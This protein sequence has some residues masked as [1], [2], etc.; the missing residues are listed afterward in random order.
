MVRALTSRMSISALLGIV[1]AAAFNRVLNFFLLSMVLATIFGAVIFI[2]SSRRLVNGVQD[3]KVRNSLYMSS[4]AAVLSTQ[5]FFL[6]FIPLTVDRSFSVWLLARIGGAEL[7]TETVETLEKDTKEFFLANSVEVNRRLDEQERL[8]NLDV[9]GG[10]RPISL[11]S[12]GKF[13]TLI[14]RVVCDFFG[15]QKKYA[16]GE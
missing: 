8:G 14:N 11:T 2:F 16:N 9:Y 3:V 12:R 13:Q 6:S 10:S 5:L 7:K 4:I 1:S 15:L